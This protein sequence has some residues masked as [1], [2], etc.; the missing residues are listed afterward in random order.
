MRRDP[1]RPLPG[2]GDRRAW[3]NKKDSD[4]A[5]EIFGLYGLTPEVDDTEVIHDEAVSTIVQ[6]E[7][8][9]QFLNRLAIR[10]GFECYVEGTT[11]Y[12]RAPV[13]DDPPQPVL[14]AQFGGDTTLGDFSIEGNRRFPTQDLEQYYQPDEGSLLQS[15][16]I[17]GDD[18]DRPAVFDQGVFEEATS[19]VRSLYSNSGYLYSQISP[20]IERVAAASEEAAPG[21]TP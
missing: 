14:A 7:T 18:R 1:P 10:N 21:P 3:P 2:R 16:G 11:G 9:M 17:G 13:L 12:F 5:R 19:S 8:D 4:I 20:E 15:L 6:R